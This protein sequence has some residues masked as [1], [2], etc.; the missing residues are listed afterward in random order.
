M[1]KKTLNE[2]LKTYYERK[3]LSPGTL[4]RL[5]S[6]VEETGK[7]ERKRWSRL[8]SFL[9]SP[10][11]Y[12][13]STPGLAYASLLILLVY[14]A[15][16]VT[17][18]PDGGGGRFDLS[19]AVAKEIAMNHR[20][21]LGVE[22]GATTIADLHRRMNKLDFEPIRSV[23]VSKTFRMIGARYCSIQGGIA[24][25]IQLADGS[26]RRYTLYQTRLV[27][28]LTR[29]RSQALEIQDLRLRL[30]RENDVFLGLI[31]PVE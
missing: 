12:R 16:M 21:Q 14:I 11:R 25:Q 22:F 24:A 1:E 8:R 13:F 31:G 2:C 18:R 19:R 3:S 15:W 23:R 5:K 28:P 29:L 30:W 6:T 17:E 4:A 20:K 9:A 26:G 10:F 7:G 27:D